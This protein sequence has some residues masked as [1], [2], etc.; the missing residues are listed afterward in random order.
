MM[1]GLSERLSQSRSESLHCEVQN[2]V[3]DCNPAHDSWILFDW[4]PEEAEERV[5]PE[6]VSIV[7]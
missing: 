1:C 5:K 2:L 7:A 3:K 6:K 4:Q